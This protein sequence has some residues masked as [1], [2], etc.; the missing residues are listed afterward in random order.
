MPPCAYEHKPTWESLQQP[1]GHRGTAHLCSPLGSRAQ[2]AAKWQKSVQATPK[3]GDS[4]AE[5]GPVSGAGRPPPPEP[6]PSTGLLP[7]KGPGRYACGCRQVVAKHRPRA[8]A[9]THTP[10]SQTSRLFKGG[11]HNRGLRGQQGPNKAASG[12]NGQ[13]EALARGPGGQAQGEMQPLREE[14]EGSGQVCTP[15]TSASRQTAPPSGGLGRPHSIRALSPLRSQRAAG[16]T[17]HERFRHR[18]PESPA[19]VC[20]VYLCTGL[21]PQDGLRWPLPRGCRGRQHGPQRRGGTAASSHKDQS[22]VWGG[23]HRSQH[24]GKIRKQDNTG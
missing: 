21:Q 22:R 13:G 16:R 6:A 15:A 12:Q 8:P 24:W 19:H 23:P 4:A 18:L 20:T 2:M 9:S 11:E 3:S 17:T 14:A 7:P 10:G 1:N 5:P